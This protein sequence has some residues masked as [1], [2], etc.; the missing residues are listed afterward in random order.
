M[1][2]GVLVDEATYFNDS[3]TYTGDSGS[4]TNRY[5]IEDVYDFL[6]IGTGKSYKNYRLVNDIDMRDHPIYKTGFN[7]KAMIKDLYGTFD[8]D[9]H[10]IR[11]IVLNNYAGSNVQNV[12]LMS[13]STI[14]N[15][16]FKN[17]I[18]SNCN[19]TCSL[20][21]C[22]GSGNLINGQKGLVNCNFGIYVANSTGES[23]PM[24]HPI[25]DCCFNIEGMI[26]NSLYLYTNI[27]R[28]QF[29]L[30][31]TISYDSVIRGDVLATFTNCYF[32]GKIKNIEKL[33]SANSI[34]NVP[35]SNSYIAVEYEGGSGYNGIKISGTGFI[36]KELWCK[37]G[38]TGLV[39]NPSSDYI[40]PIT[41]AQAQDANYLNSIG[42]AVVPVE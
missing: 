11:N 40:R 24:G 6:A 19:A 38:F 1:A 13:F 10:S 14:A 37:N 27:E 21:F 20:I 2:N 33:E 29:N 4:E 22:S 32:T 39:D 34:C 28:T 16:D 12:A 9:G 42:F 25:T 23:L 7:A 15:V 18:I 5:V 17:L 8:G 3:E 36:D 31:I 30:N 26:T 41:T 35:F